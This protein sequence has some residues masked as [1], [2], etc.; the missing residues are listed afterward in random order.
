MSAI[1]DSIHPLRRQFLAYVQRGDVQHMRELLAVDHGLAEV[2]TDQGLSAILL[3]VYHAQSS[4][5]E[6]L[7]QTGKQLSI[8]EAAVLGLTRQVKGLV[9][10]DSKLANAEAADGFFPLGLAVFFGHLDTVKSLLD[11]GADIDQKSNNLQK[12]SPL[13]SAVAAGHL[14]IARLLIQRGADVNAPQQAGYTPLIAAAAAGQV[15]MVKN[16]LSAG[17]DPSARLDDGRTALDLAVEK[18]LTSV[19]ELLKTQP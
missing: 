14:E 2:R 18:G 5:A 16:L 6:L 9:E 11:H 19:A 13:N 4:A 8:F 1:E 7:V 3:A 15:E 17:A 12:V 10:G